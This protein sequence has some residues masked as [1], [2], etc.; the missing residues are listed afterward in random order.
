MLLASR[1]T[2]ASKEQIEAECHIKEDC[3]FL[4]AEGILEPV[5][6]FEIMAQ[7][8]AA[9]SGLVYPVP[10]GY[11]AGMKRMRVFA[12][13]KA[14]DTLRCEVR[15]V[16]QI[17]SIAVIDGAVFREDECLAEGQFKIYLPNGDKQ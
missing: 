13:A 1:L 11:L 16:A 8:F 14:G 5:A 15:P 17:D 4:D 7:S 6:L 12:L 3:I 9:G 10:W 2:G